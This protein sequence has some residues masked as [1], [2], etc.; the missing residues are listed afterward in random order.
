MSIRKHIWRI[1]VLSVLTAATALVSFFGVKTA[2]LAQGHAAFTA[3]SYDTVL[4]RSGNEVRKEQRLVAVRRDGS[5]VN[6][7]YL[8]APDERGLAAQK[9][10][11][12]LPRAE[13]VSS[14][15]LTESVTT[16]PL[17]KTAVEYYQRLPECTIQDAAERSTMLGYEV[18]RV[19]RQPGTPGDNMIVRW[20]DWVA[21][22]LNC[23]PLKRTVLRGRAE[24]DLYISNVSEVYQV[25]VGE[26]EASLFERPAGYVERSPLQRKEEFKKRYPETAARSCESCSQSTSEAEGL[27]LRRQ[28]DRSR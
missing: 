18:V 11:L 1:V 20:D 10:I 6:V 22:A 23:F 19:V 9:H 5:R 25:K 8:R 4:D 17:R 16:L 7:R 26:P 15:E 12:D 27:Y 28:S 2:A 14:D 24:A 3:M 21:P 13:E